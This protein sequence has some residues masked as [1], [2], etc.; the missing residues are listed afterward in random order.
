MLAGKAST[1]GR[2][3]S[4]A[5]LGTPSECSKFFQTAL[6]LSLS[7]Q[8]LV[9]R[10]FVWFSCV[11]FAHL[12]CVSQQGF[13]GRK[14]RFNC[15]PVDS[16]LVF[17]ILSDCSLPH[18]LTSITK[19]RWKPILLYPVVHFVFHFLHLRFGSWQSLLITTEWHFSPTVVDGDGSAISPC[20]PCAMVGAI[21]YCC[22]F[23]SVSSRTAA[24]RNE[25]FLDAD[26]E[27]GKSD[28]YTEIS[29]RN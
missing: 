25:K 4:V 2:S 13:H 11:S 7:V 9:G 10:P 14:I 21:L 29:N 17:R 1:A 18:S 6:F 3:D 19:A 23:R 28:H 20:S 26:P 27:S 15:F 5:S 24:Y 8:K 22:S 12:G 16:F